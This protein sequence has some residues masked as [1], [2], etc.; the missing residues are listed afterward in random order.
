[1]QILL[2]KNLF[3]FGIYYIYFL[4]ITVEKSSWNDIRKRLWCCINS[5]VV[6][7]PVFMPYHCLGILKGCGQRPQKVW[8]L[9][10][11]LEHMWQRPCRLTASMASGY[12]LKGSQGLLPLARNPCLE[13]FISFSVFFQ[14]AA[15]KCFLIFCLKVFNL[16]TSQEKVVRD[17]YFLSLTWRRELDDLY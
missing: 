3:F 16:K 10:G 5:A 7:Q 6:R 13:I 4:F 1:M 2:K 14:I 17:N 11:M 15:N 8:D 12:F 9:P